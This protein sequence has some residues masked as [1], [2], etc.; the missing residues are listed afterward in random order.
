DYRVLVSWRFTITPPLVRSNVSR[1]CLPIAAGGAS[2]LPDESAPGLPTDPS[3]H[4]P[5]TPSGGC[6][7]APSH[8]T[9]PPESPY[10]VSRGW[11]DRVRGSPDDDTRSLLRAG[12]RRSRAGSNRPAAIARSR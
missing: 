1:H 8:G 11:E 4:D 12:G 2:S 3:T 10:P 9:D 7:R 6:R 5:Q